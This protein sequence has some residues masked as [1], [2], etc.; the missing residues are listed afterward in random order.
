MC[1]GV[2]GNLSYDDTLELIETFGSDVIPEFDQDPVHS[3]THHRATARPK[4][5]AFNS[6]PPD[7]RTAYD[8]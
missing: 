4:F 3:T 2:P 7:I 5:P 6:P 8:G 1:F